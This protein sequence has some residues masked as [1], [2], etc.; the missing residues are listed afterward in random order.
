VKS[1]VI[2]GLQ[3][4]TLTERIWFA[5]SSNSV[6]AGKDLNAS[7]DLTSDSSFPD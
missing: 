3:E 5:C 4:R 1:S 2:T 7:L 6:F